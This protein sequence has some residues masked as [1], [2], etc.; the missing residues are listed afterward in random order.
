MRVAGLSILS[1]F[2]LLGLTPW[3]HTQELESRSAAVTSQ[4]DGYDATHMLTRVVELVR[5]QYV[6]QSKVSYEELYQAAA[7][8]V[9]SSLDPHSQFLDEDAFSAMQKDTSGE[10]SGLGL[11]VGAKDRAIVV[12]SAM[13]GT[14]SHRAGIL[15]GDRILKIDGVSTED[16]SLNEAVKHMKGEN[17]ESIRLTLLRRNDAGEGTVIEPI[18]Q[19]ETIRVATVRAAKILPEE[20][21]GK[22]RIGYVRL[23]Q[24]GE[25]TEEEFAD[26]LGKLE[27]EGMEALVLDLRNNPGGLLDS[28]VEVAGKFLPTGQVIVSTKGRSSRNSYEYTAASTQRAGDYPLAVLVNAYSASG[29]EIVAGALQDLDRAVLVGE[30]TFGKGSVQ[31]VQSLGEGIGLRLTTAHYYTPSKKVIHEVGVS[32][33]ISVPIGREEEEKLQLATRPHLL[34]D[35]QKEQVRNLRDTQLERAV[36]ALKGINLWA[37]REQLRNKPEATRQQAANQSLPAPA[38]EQ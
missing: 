37:G 11:M 27:A 32:P 19:R 12:L 22:T 36:V 38:R 13:E 34:D 30:T 16:M 9:L 4:D 1:L 31:S 33:D 7:K 25:H 20:M 17:G 6:D 26:A 28:A 15:P 29:A 8:G 21:T 3:A 23:E 2:L 10:F 18:M 5:E 14:P 35:E 24:F